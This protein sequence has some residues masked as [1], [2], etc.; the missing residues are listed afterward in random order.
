M[1]RPDLIA[2]PTAERLAEAAV[3]LLDAA[4][5]ANAENPNFE[6][7]REYVAEPCA[8]AVQ[9]LFMADIWDQSD[10]QDMVRLNPVH[11]RERIRGLAYGLGISLSILPPP[12]QLPCTVAMQTGLN[13][14][15]QLGRAARQA[16]RS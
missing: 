9:A 4:R 7:G 5:A 15:L 10:S 12:A 11:T 13:Q 1:D 16:H 8:L 2:R 14:G 6:R 3:A